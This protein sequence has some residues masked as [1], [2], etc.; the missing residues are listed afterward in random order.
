M[1]ILKSV[2][3]KVEFYTV[4][5]TGQSGM[6]QTGLSLLAGISRQSLIQLEEV[7]KTRAPSEILKNFVGN[8]LDIKLTDPTIGGK[9]QGNL[10]IYKASF[11]AAV[12]K[13]YSS[14]EEEDK[15]DSRPATYSLVR[16]AEIGINKWIQ[17]ITGWTE[18][19]DKI[20]PHTSIYINRIEAR[21][22]H[23][24][25]D[26]VWGVFLEA[27]DVLLLLEKDWRV[28]INDFDI[29]DGSIGRR[30]RDYR[31][32]KDWA[33]PEDNNFYDHTFRDQRGTRPVRAYKWSERAE[34]A[35]WL[36][37][38]YVPV[39]LPTY[40]VEKYGKS[41]TRLIYTENGLL[42]DEILRLT[43]V[44]RKSPADEKKLEEFL[45]ARNQLDSLESRQ[46]EIE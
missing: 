42:N 34:F 17:D 7:L 2:E 28:P 37:S 14:I 44:K 6:S 21:R 29:L 5:I 13:H 26:D 35:K 15:L 41:V 45:A 27:G 25:S 12:L 10:K 22:D 38:E 23:S 24:I 9:A 1:E 43:E 31:S 3:N 8:D 19:K 40:L 4:A 36:R 16:F 30:W 33:D 39:H 46:K 32:D 11:C 18:F 20:Q